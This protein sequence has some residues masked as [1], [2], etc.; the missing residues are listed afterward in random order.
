MFVKYLQCIRCGERYSPGLNYN[1]GKCDNI[2]D[3]KYDYDSIA[4]RM[5]LRKIP[6]RIQ[7]LWRYNDLLPVDDSDNIVSLNEG[8]TPLRKCDRLGK[9]LGLENLYVKD[10]TRNPTGSFKDRPMTVAI[11][12]AREFGAKTVTSSSSG[13]A[14]VSLAAYAAKAGL[15]C[16]VFAPTSAPKTKLMLITLYGSKIVSVNGTCSDTFKLAKKASKHY[17]WFNATST[18]IN[19]YQVEGD[20][21]VAYELCDNLDWKTPDWIFIPISDGPLLV[22]CWKGFKELKLLGYCADLPHMVGIQAE[23]C[24]PISRAFKENAVNVKP[25]GTPTTIVSSIADPLVGY[26]QDGTYTL[27][28]I[29]ESDGVADACSDKDI[30]DSVKLLAKKEGIFA[31]PAGAAPIAGVKKLFEQGRI[32]S[33]ETTV[34]LVTG[35]GLKDPNIF[36]KSFER[37]RS[38]EPNFN[39]LTQLVDKE[40]VK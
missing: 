36:M 10:E 17:G 37:P 7:S 28:N 1:C 21:T 23:G 5:D 16:I 40:L 31:E 34:C 18:F 22:G 9:V 26:S 15:D 35:T 30:L 33:D 32:D 3:I 14:G 4:N 29:R 11:T 8:G 20:K 25:W 13:N 2:L 19:P 39:K 12:K 6:K 38:I 27:K 24:A